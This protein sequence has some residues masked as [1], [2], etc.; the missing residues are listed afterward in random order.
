[1]R[2]L[3]RFCPGGKCMVPLLP[4]K[5][6]GS[7]EGCG[8]LELPP[9]HS[10]PLVKPKWQVPVAPNPLQQCKQYSGD[11]ALVNAKL[12]K[13]EGANDYRTHCR[14]TQTVLNWQIA[15]ARYWRNQQVPAAANPLQQHQQ[16]AG[17]RLLMRA[18]LLTSTDSA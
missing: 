11:C 6:P 16:S 8:V 3:L 15:G 12:S 13:A 7:D 9:H 10:V 14:S 4:Q 2:F 5:L 17:D 18:S 1:M